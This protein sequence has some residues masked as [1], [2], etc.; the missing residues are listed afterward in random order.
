M[1]LAGYAVKALTEELSASHARD[2]PRRA[3]RE[4]ESES[5]EKTT[6]I[7]DTRQ[8]DGKHRKKEQWF[9]ENGIRTIRSKLPMGDYALLT[10]LSRVVDTK[11]NLQELV[12]NLIHDHERFRREADF[13]KENGIEL[14]V[15]IEEEGMKTLE[16]VKKWENPRLHYYNKVRYMHRIGK[17]QNVPEPDQKPPTSNTTLYKIMRTFSERHST[18]FEFCDPKD[19]GRRV[20]EILKEGSERHNDE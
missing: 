11:R 1:V 14:V 10:D 6:I 12:G 16:D 2:S 13:C 17:W 5:M 19:A 20:V 9:H 4:P 15:L 8:H 7:C 18:R 3:R